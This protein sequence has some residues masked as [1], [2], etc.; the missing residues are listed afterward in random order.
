[1]ERS[2][3]A[4]VAA[5]EKIDPRRIVGMAMAEAAKDTTNVAVLYADVGRRFGLDIPEMQV[6][7]YV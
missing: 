2:F 7:G 6:G 3:A 4:A 5:F 1:M